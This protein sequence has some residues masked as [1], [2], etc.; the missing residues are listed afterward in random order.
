MSG[1][2]IV[3]QQP[4][5]IVHSGRKRRCSERAG[6]LTRRTEAVATVTPGVSPNFEKWSPMPEPS[7]T[8]SAEPVTKKSK[9]HRLLADENTSR[10]FRRGVRSTHCGQARLLTE[11]YRGV[12]WR[13]DC[14]PAVTPSLELARCETSGAA[15]QAGD[16]KRGRRR[17]QSSLS[18]RR[19]NSSGTE[20]PTRDADP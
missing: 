12:T 4:W 6:G 8:R 9:P 7:P 1:R 3:L 5:Q 17:F 16:P 11:F 14:Y 18:A 15:K 13:Q 10:R 20:R 2:S 19:R